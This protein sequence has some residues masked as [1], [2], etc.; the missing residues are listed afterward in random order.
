[1]NIIPDDIY[2]RYKIEVIKCW[3]FGNLKKFNGRIVEYFDEIPLI[4]ERTIKN[5]IKYKMICD[6]FTTCDYYIINKDNIK[7]GSTSFEICLD[8]WIKEKLAT[9]ESRKDRIKW[10]KEFIGNNRKHTLNEWFHFMEYIYEYSD[11][12]QIQRFANI[13]H[14]N[15][16]NECYVLNDFIDIL[17]GPTMSY[18]K[19]IHSDFKE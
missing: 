10:F 4:R 12:S 1:M 8:F 7:V 14:V 2:M 13:F 6:D 18:I 5:V 19:Q 3:H 11:Y 9:I 17:D 15:L 16:D